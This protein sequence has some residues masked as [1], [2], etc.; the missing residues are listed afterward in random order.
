MRWSERQIAMLREMGIRVWSREAPGA[1]G[2]V[3]AGGEALVVEEARPFVAEARAPATASVVR[4]QAPRDASVPTAPTPGP[5]QAPAL[6]SA[7]WLLVGEPFD[8]T[9][10]AGD[11]SAAAADHER[12][13][14]NMLR[15]IR[16]SRTVPGREG[17]ACYL[18]IVESRPVDL[19]EAMARVGPRCILVFGRA[20]ASV[21]LGLDEPLGRLRERLHERLH[22]RSGVP[23]V[24]TFALPYLLRHPVDKP[25]A[26]ADLC[27][28]VN[29]LG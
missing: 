15:A 14:D 27:R 22:E 5:N 9:G 16:V 13:L 3:A 26:W 25:K 10:T 24:V 8:A 2:V 20:A 21:V 29:A 7:D 17:R 1:E 6:A 23:V 19:D 12:L 4:Y 18:P 11:P 28:A